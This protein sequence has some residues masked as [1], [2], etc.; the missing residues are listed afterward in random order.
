MPAIV[1]A[2][3]PAV[4]L[5]GGVRVDVELLLFVLFVVP[6]HVTTSVLTFL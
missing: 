6:S 5:R 3:M 1:S 4:V 2:V